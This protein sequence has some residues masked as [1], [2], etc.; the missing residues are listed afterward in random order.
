MGRIK[1][2]RL[3]TEIKNNPPVIFVGG[4]ERSGTSMIRAII[5]SHPE[6][7]VFQSDHS[8]W[9]RSFPN[10]SVLWEK[11]PNQHVAKLLLT[12][13]CTSREYDELYHKPQFDMVYET[14]QRR[15]LNDIENYNALTKTVFDAFMEE[16]R[17]LREKPQWA[18]KS[19]GSEFFAEQILEAYPDAKFLHVYRNIMSVSSSRK[20][21][22]WVDH[23]SWG[24]IEHCTRWGKSLELLH[25]NANKF[26]GRYL[27]INYDGFVKDPETYLNLICAF[28]QIDFH[29]QMLQMNKQPGWN[30]SNSSYDEPVKAITT[31]FAQR[32]IENLSEEEINIIDTSTTIYELSIKEKFPDFSIPRMEASYLNQLGE[33]L[34]SSGNDDL[35]I[36]A[37]KKAIETDASYAMPI[38]NLG[39]LFWNQGDRVMA[40]KYLKEAL[41]VDANRLV[42]TNLGQVFKE[43]GE[44]ETANKLY[45]SYLNQF[46]EDEYIEQ[47]KQELVLMKDQISV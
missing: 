1:N 29:P 35:A 39:V 13:L 6:I 26:R 16:Y 24:I 3:S 14:L 19:P 9:I 11:V 7:A 30:G 21:I 40:L 44:F 23:K 42:I 37:F 17:K 32:K 15:N 34:Y 27:G 5:G 25:V 20:K 47:Q 2:S 41:Q 10:R 43:V 4:M 12:D 8:F 36:N 18:F 28:L 46:P 33:D 22:G 38:N 31:K 45:S